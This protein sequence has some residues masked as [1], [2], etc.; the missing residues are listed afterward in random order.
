MLYAVAAG[1]EFLLFR[2]LP[3]LHLYTKFY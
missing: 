2:N 1:A 3:R